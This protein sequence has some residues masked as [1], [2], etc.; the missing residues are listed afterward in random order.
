MYIIVNGQ[1]K[2]WSEYAQTEDKTKEII[3][4]MYQILL[5]KINNLFLNIAQEQ[6]RV[7]PNKTALK[8]K[9]GKTF[10]HFHYTMNEKIEP[11]LNNSDIGKRKNIIYRIE[12]VFTAIFS[13]CQETLE[14]PDLDEAKKNIILSTLDELIK[15]VDENKRPEN[16]I[17]KRYKSSE[18]FEKIPEEL[19]IQIVNRLEENSQTTLKQ[20]EEIESLSK[21]I[22]ELNKKIRE[23]ESQMQKI[24]QIE[25]SKKLNPLQ[26]A[27]LAN[28]KKQKS[29]L[30][31]QKNN[32]QK[33]IDLLKINNQLLRVSTQLLI[34]TNT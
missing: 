19:E 17:F 34:K 31:Q 11:L 13:Y 16:S 28:L 22:E 23:L 3:E 14:F 20:N 5:I 8:Y 33:Q 12:I 32:I 7:M 21:K 26:K 29:D 15:P 18:K 25:K 9:I 30:C 2:K 27:R 24:Y 4:D 1:K 6:E 10:Q